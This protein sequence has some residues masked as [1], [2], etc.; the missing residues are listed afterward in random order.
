M[1]GPQV[2]SHVDMLS[3]GKLTLFTI[4]ATFGLLE[5][6]QSI[7]SI[8]QINTTLHFFCLIVG[9]RGTQEKPDQWENEVTQD[10]QDLQESK[11]YLVQL[12]KKGQRSKI[13]SFTL[14]L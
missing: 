9:Y 4:E 3:S 6:T 14:W 2:S 12:A 5:T 10:P 8:G 13:Q 7:H 1:V 11:V